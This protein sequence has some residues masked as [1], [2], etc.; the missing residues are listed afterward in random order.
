MNTLSDRSAFLIQNLSTLNLIDTLVN[1]TNIAGKGKLPAEIGV[2]INYV[3]GSKFSI[4]VDFSLAKWS[5][6]FNNP[7]DTKA[8][9]LGDAT[10]I[11]LGGFYLPDAKSYSNYWKRTTYKYGAYYKTDPRI[12]NGK[13]ID[14]YGLTVGLGLPFVFQ[15]SFSQANLGLDFGRLGQGSPIE[16]NYVKLNFGFTF[17]DDNWFIKRKYN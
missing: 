8:G 6:Y 17:N 15:R 12:I 7:T 9:D 5:S 13:Q 1:E 2:G 4:G 3:N 16:E 10:S 14:Q 11:S